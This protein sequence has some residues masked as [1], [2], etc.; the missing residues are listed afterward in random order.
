[1][2]KEKTDRLL[3]VNVNWVGDV[4]FSTPAIRAL[5][6]RYPAAHIACMVVPR[7]KEVLE[8]NPHLNE[9][10]I[11]DEKGE[12]KGLMG[13][14]RLI[15]ALKAQPERKLIWAAWLRQLERSEPDY[16]N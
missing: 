8:L 6:K 10:I 11:Y 2:D 12:Y 1:M 5:R 15:S 9:L 16:K 3:I 7:C 14:L 4:L 13:K